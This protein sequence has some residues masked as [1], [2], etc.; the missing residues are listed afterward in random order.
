MLEKFSKNWK[1]KVLEINR[2]SPLRVFF[3]LISFLYKKKFNKFNK[4]RFFFRLCF[5]SLTE[6]NDENTDDPDEEN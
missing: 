4:K 6:T 2:F 3:S 1:K 5:S